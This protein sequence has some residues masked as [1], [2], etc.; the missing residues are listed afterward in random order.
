[1]RWTEGKTSFIF[2]KLNLRHIDFSAAGFRDFVQRKHRNSLVKHIKIIVPK[3]TSEIFL[4]RSTWLA[5]FPE[6]PYWVKDCA[7][8]FTRIHCIMER[9]SPNSFFSEACPR[10][11]AAIPRKSASSISANSSSSKV[12]LS[13]SSKTPEFFRKNLSK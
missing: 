12:R 7:P 4:G 3:P 6:R 8:S 9:W 13:F 2:S 1:M 5:K 10:S 11:I